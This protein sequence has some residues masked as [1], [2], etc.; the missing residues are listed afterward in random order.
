MGKKGRK[1]IKNLNN[2]LLYSEA[3]PYIVTIEKAFF[4]KATCLFALKSRFHR[5]DGNIGKINIH[6]NPGILV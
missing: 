6:D 3:T 1:K 2:W 4:L 5:A